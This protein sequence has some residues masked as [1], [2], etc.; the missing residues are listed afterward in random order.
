MCGPHDHGCLALQVVNTANHLLNSVQ[1]AHSITFSLGQMLHERYVTKIQYRPDLT[2]AYDRQIHPGENMQWSK[3]YNMTKLNLRT[4]SWP[5][6][7]GLR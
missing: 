6:L 4:L 5:P 3:N 7:I 2:L 1:T